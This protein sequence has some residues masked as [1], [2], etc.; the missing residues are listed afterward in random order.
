M[1]NIHSDVYSLLIDSY[2]KDK[3]EKNKL[4]KAIDNFP[5]IKKKLT[6]L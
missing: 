3:T 4:F 5:C 1:E 2:V 6:G